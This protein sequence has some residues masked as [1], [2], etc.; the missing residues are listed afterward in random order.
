MPGSSLLRRDPCSRED[1]DRRLPPG[2][3]FTEFRGYNQATTGGFHETPHILS[4]PKIY[5]VE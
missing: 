3:K 5:S 2:F 4:C 1:G